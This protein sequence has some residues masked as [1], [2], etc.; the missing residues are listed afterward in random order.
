M[1]DVI[2]AAFQQTREY[3]LWGR[4]DS[5]VDWQAALRDGHADRAILVKDPEDPRDDFYL[6]QIHPAQPIARTAWV[7]LDAATLKLRE[8]SLLDNWPAIAFPNAQDQHRAAQRPLTLPDGTTA[9]FRKEELKPNLRNL[10]WRASA[11]TLLPYWP[12][13]E[14]CAAHPL[15]REPISIYV[16]QHGEVYTALLPDETPATPPPRIKQPS[17]LRKMLWVAATAAAA[18]IAGYNWHPQAPPDRSGE[19]EKALT[20]L[21]NSQKT[22]EDTQMKLAELAKRETAY[23]ASIT[24]L[25]GEITR[26]QQQ[27]ALA[28]LEGA[29]PTNPVDLGPVVRSLLDE[30]RKSADPKYREE[31]RGKILQ[32]FRKPPNEPPQR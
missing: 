14:L 27:L 12:V 22:S 30:F 23:R 19:L 11:A 24:R 15:T 3:G 29:G 28:Q 5:P 26:L 4:A 7:I 21:R 1:S 17:V 13:K 8:A 6:I 31:I 16:T 9:H 20:E 18:G 10:V 25:N 32:E 2:A